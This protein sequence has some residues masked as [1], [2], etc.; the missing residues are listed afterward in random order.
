MKSGDSLY[1]VA[2]QHKVSVEELKRVNGIADATKV[3]PG[4][5]LA[6]P[7]SAEPMADT[8]PNLPPRVVQI[9]PR[10]IRATPEEPKLDALPKTAK[11]ADITTD[12]LPAPALA[13]GRFRWPVRGKVIAGFGP[14]PNG[15]KHEGINLAAPLG[16]DVHAAEA[17]KVHYA[18]DGL[19]SYGNLILIRHDGDWTTAYAH[20][21]RILVKPNDVVKRGQ[22]IAKVGK[23]GPVT[24]PQLRFE[25]RKNSVPVD[26]LPHL[27]N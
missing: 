7:G 27:A 25:L 22:V 19:K 1:A 2:A 21:D 15:S 24:Q 10:I 20:V 26:P 9:K 3:R 12:A 11:R 4:T 13:T 14:Q 18:S 23:T 16:T 8:P 17:G 6:V 5:K